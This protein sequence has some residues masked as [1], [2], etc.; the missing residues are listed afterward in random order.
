[1]ITRFARIIIK[2]CEFDI[3]KIFLP[4]LRMNSNSCKNNDISLARYDIR[5]C[6]VIYLLRKH[7]I[8]SVLS[9]A[10]GIYR[11]PKVD[12]I[13]KIYHP[14]SEERISLKN[15]KFRQKLVV[16]LGAGSGG[17][18]SVCFAL[19]LFVYCRARRP[20]RAVANTM[21]DKNLTGKPHI[22]M[23]RR[24][25]AYAFGTRLRRSAGKTVHRT[26]FLI[27][28]PSRVRPPYKQKIRSSI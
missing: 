28:R 21:F 7:D 8:I 5:R 23:A 18:P 6:R 9:Y 13:S 17:R 20:R 3:K 22:L 19:D 2:F 27:R 10:A 16:F 24:P 15:D 11:P 26:L 25:K 4:F 14:F 1:M 12:I